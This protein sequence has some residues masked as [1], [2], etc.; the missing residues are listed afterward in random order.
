MSYIGA[1][2][3]VSVWASTGRGAIVCKLSLLFS[4]VTPAGVSCVRPQ[5]LVYEQ[6]LSSSLLDGFI[7]AAQTLIAINLWS[8]GPVEQLL[9]P[10]SL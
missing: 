6:Q 10:E 2:T 1:F 7:S 3:I 9:Q 4:G 5:H 8:G